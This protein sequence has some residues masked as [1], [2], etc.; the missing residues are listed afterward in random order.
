ML[1]FIFSIIV[2]FIIFIV[3]IVDLFSS[4]LVKI[5]KR[6]QRISKYETHNGGFY[7]LIQQK[8]FLF[9]KWNNCV[10]H[11]YDKI[12]RMETSLEKLKFYNEE[13]A[14]A[15]LQEYID[16]YYQ[17]INEKN[18]NKIKNKKVIEITEKYE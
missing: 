2:L 12:Y 11:K 16:K 3:F 14:K 15:K 4:K 1:L 10:E 18:G 5:N 7:F 8:H 13:K 6:K 17:K 9:N